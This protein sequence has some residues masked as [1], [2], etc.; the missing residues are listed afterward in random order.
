MNAIKSQGPDG[1]KAG[2]V[3]VLICRGP[4]G[5]GMEEIAQITIALRYLPFGKEVAVVT[6]AR[7]SG[8]ST[9]AC[10]GHVG[11]EAL[12]GGPPSCCARAAARPACRCRPAGRYAPVGC[13][14]RRGWRH[15][16]RLYI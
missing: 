11:P 4:M 10:I 5:T 3:I 8:V 9:G 6:D 1:I 16:G 14:S 7:F 2:E 12:T 15:L 13:S